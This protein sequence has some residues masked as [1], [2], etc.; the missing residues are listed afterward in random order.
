MNKDRYLH[1]GCGQNIL[2]K[3]FENLDIRELEGVDHISEVF[4]LSFEDNT[5]DLVYSSHVLEHF[6][7]SKTQ[8]I[9]N[10]WV[11]VL[12]PG[13]TLRLSVPSFENLSL[14]Y[15]KTG[16]LESI[17]G[18]LMG[19]QTYKQNFHYNAFDRKTLTQY[20]SNAGLIAIH[21]W[22]YRRTSH[23]EYW[24]FSQATTEE[25]AIS[26]NIEGRKKYSNSENIQLSIDKVKEE[27]NFL[28]ENN[29]DIKHI[30]N[31]N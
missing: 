28:K 3:P 9:I 14:I 21:P 17:I 12:K 4:P 18:P 30:F 5:F 22:D 25:I 8:E 19:G 6:E 29:I 15:Q 27:L 31:N 16:K 23:S 26:V 13:G 1:I 2:P 7:K 11:R 24:D 10:E 20:L